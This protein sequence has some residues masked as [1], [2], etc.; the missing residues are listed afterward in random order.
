MFTV[1]VIREMSTKI[2]L[3]LHLTPVRMTKINRT[4]G[5]KGWR[6]V[7]KQ[8]AHSVD[9]TANWYSH[10]RNQCDEFIKGYK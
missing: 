8:N 1:L 3:R 5:N 9:G 7:G 4:T 2:A 10:S 6:S